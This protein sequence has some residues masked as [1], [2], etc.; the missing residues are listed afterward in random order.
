MKGKIFNAQEVQAILNKSK[1]MFREVIKP[2]PNDQQK[3]LCDDDNG[4]VFMSD[5]D[6]ARYAV[7]GDGNEI[8]CPYQLGQKIFCKE[9]F[10]TCADSKLLN[11]WNIFYQADAKLLKES[12]WKPAQHMTQEHS[13]LTL[14][15]KE[16]KVERLAGISEE[17]AIAE[18]V[19]KI[20]F[21]E[22]LNK[23]QSNG[24]LSRISSKKY[25]YYPQEFRKL[26]NATHKKPEEKFEA[27]PF[28]WVIS[29]EAFTEEREYV[30]FN[31]KPKIDIKKWQQVKRDLPAVLKNLINK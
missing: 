5:H 26:W 4:N 25:Q 1:V 9:S 11:E 6:W 27:N 30:E 17:D 8:K 23:E 12:G 10:W 16:I 24:F 2:Q 3:Y 7:F 13:R 20:G 28:V 29:F 31:L 22:L 19:F 18:G 14:L 15:I 21:H